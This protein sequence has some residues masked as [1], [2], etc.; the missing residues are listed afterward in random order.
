MFKI[1]SVVKL[2]SDEIEWLS[3]ASK[4]LQDHLSVSKETSKSVSKETKEHIKDKL[5]LDKAKEEPKVN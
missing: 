1:K 5:T 4:I 3:N 2:N